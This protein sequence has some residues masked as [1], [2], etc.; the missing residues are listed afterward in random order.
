MNIL[1]SDYDMD[2]D[3]PDDIPRYVYNPP[4]PSENQN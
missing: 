2:F 4:P 3:L 1:D